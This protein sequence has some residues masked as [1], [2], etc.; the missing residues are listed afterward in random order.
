MQANEDEKEAVSNRKGLLDVASH[1]SERCVV[2]SNIIS[3]I[4]DDLHGHRST[5][6]QPL[7]RFRIGNTSVRIRGELKSL[8]RDS[9][10][11]GMPV[12]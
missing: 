9:R 1:R 10:I 4:P 5:R 3:L 12:I 6:S 7:I 11:T 8:R 2:V